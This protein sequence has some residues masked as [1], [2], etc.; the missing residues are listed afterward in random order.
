MKKVTVIGSGHVGATTAYLIALREIASTLLFDVVEGLP[1]GTT[2]DMMESSPLMNFRAG[3]KGSN[4]F[5]E[6]ADSDLVV[7]TAGQARQPGM[8][9]SDLLASNAKIVSSIV[10]KI[11]EYA[12]RSIILVVTN[13]LDIMT[14]LAYRQSGFSPNNVFGMGGVLDSSRMAYF[15]ALAL[16]VPTEEVEALVIGSHSDAMLP[17]PRLTKV[18]GQ[19]LTDLLDSEGIENIVNRTRNAGAEIVSFL[20]TGSAFYAPAAAITRMVESIFED[21]KRVFSSCVY[22]NGQYGFRDLCLNVPVR[23][24]ARGVEEIIEIGLSER[25]KEALEKS[26]ESVRQGIKEIKDLLEK[27]T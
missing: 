14:Y 23:L 25:E 22:L 19:P 2:L 5:E 15:V 20:K 27:D 21:E 7:I 4:S 26:A 13:P 1:Q 9:R 6:V 12:P 24:G 3:I 16:S 11:V 17:L 10:E 18:K 8:S